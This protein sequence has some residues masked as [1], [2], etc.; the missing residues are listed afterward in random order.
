MSQLS[1]LFR[2]V[3]KKSNHP[4]TLLHNLQ[5]ARAKQKY[6]VQGQLGDGA[7]GTALELGAPEE[8]KKGTDTGKEGNFEGVD[9]KVLEGNSGMRS[10]AQGGE[11]G[12][13]REN[14]GK[15]S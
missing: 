1:G 9:E 5:L 11:G 14:R 12:G 3:V 13:S 4:N 8:L 15:V 10:E 6:L 7:E 2:Q